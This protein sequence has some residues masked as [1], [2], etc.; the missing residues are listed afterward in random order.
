MTSRKRARE[1]EL[2]NNGGSEY[3]RVLTQTGGAH[4][5]VLARSSLVH[6]SSN[7]ESHK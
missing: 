1:P 6:P 4:F 7:M 5:Q 2:R 3:E